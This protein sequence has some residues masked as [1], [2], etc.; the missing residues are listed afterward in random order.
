MDLKLLMIIMY[1]M[2]ANLFGK[3]LPKTILIPFLT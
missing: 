2:I 1:F 3:K